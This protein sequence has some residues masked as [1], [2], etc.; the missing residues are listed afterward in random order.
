M[1][2]SAQN[3]V[4]REVAPVIVLHEEK[5]PRVKV[6]VDTEE[7]EFRVD[8]VVGPWDVSARLREVFAFLQENLKDTDVELRNVEYAACNGMLHTLDPHSVFL[9]P[10]A[11][12]EMNLSTSGHFGGL[13][14]VISI[15]DQMLTVMRPMPGTP[16]ARANLKRLDRITKINNES[17]LNM[18]LDDA[19]NRLRGKPGTKVT[20]W[21]H[22]DGNEGWA[23][24][25]PFELTREEIQIK[26][27]EARAL[28]P[29]VGYIRL[30]QFQSS[31]D[32]ELEEALAELN[33]KE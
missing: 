12:R 25:R 15:R 14:I 4:Q 19:V 21:I 16:A 8:T 26:S 10:D 32:D 31:T 20:V 2:L 17:T 23:G 9:S 11:Y 22:R 28:Q 27:V 5:S 3:Q 13:G 1:F 29:G 30:K 7:K 24:A 6:R 18:P 33:K